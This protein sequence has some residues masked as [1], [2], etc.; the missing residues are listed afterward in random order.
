MKAPVESVDPGQAPLQ[1]W[2]AWCAYEGTTLYGWQSQVG[3]NTV[4]DFIEA[5][6]AEI[7]KCPVRIHGSGRTDSG[8]HAR[9]QI[10]HFDAAWSHPVEYLERALRTGLP[11][12]IQV[13]R[14]RR[15]SGT[16]HARYSAVGKR[17]R[18]YMEEGHPRPWERNYCWGLGQ[19]KLDTGSMR[20]AAS[21]LLGV[22]DFSAFGARR[23]G[24]SEDNPVKDLR[25]LEV[26]R[27]GR[28]IILTTEASGYLYKMV[29]SLTGTLVEVGL[30]KMSP[31][32][33]AEMLESRQRTHLVPT[34]PACG[35]W[36]ERV[37]Y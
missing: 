27:R 18:Y 29:R 25:L 11:G 22:H 3:G 26:V 23:G 30:G 17:Y 1:R 20:E 5:R 13:Y 9:A 21:R 14:V 36:L 10:F 16:F 6:L 35:L 12:S 24:D 37:Y 32:E 4:Q 19:R 34:A 33:V 31:E 15:V 7:F 8:V 28:K 2:K